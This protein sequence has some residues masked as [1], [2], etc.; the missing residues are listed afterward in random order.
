MKIKLLKHIVFIAFIFAAISLN[1]QPQDFFLK[2][3]N[4]LHIFNNNDVSILNSSF[5]AKSTNNNKWIKYQKFTNDANNFKNLASR[6]ASNPRRKARFEKK[7]QKYLRKAAKYQ[8][9]ALDSYIDANNIIKSKY[10]AKISSLSSPETELLDTLNDIRMFY[11]DSIRMNKLDNSSDMIIR[12]NKRQ[13]QYNYENKVILYMEYQLAILAG[14]SSIITP[15]KEKYFPQTQTVVTN[16]VV[17]DTVPRWDY[18]NDEFFFYPI[19]EEMD[20]KILYSS[21]NFTNL[22][23]YF[24]LGNTAFLD[25]NS[26]NSVYDSVSVYQTKLSQTSDYRKR[27]AISTKVSEFQQ[28]ALALEIEALKKYYSSN[29]LFF[30]IRKERIL[31][32]PLPDTAN[33]SYKKM[34]DYINKAEQFYYDADSSKRKSITLAGI[35][36]RNSIDRGNQ[37]MVT[38][39]EYLENAFCLKYNFDTNNVMIRNKLLTNTFVAIV[40]PPDTTS[41]SNNNST[42]NATT[43]NTRTNN[44]SK[45][46]R[47]SGLF[48][49]SYSSR[50]PV[51][52]STPNGTIY[53]VQVGTSIDLL[54]V[55]E[56]REYDKIYYEQFT[57]TSIKKFLVGDY[58]NYDDAQ[59]TLNKL[60]NS[61]YITAVIVKYVEGKRQGATYSSTYGTTNTSTGSF[62][63]VSQLKV[64]TYLIQLGTYS[65]PKTS[66]DLANYQNVYVRR[67]ANGNYEYFQG[68]Y[69]RY[70]NAEVALP[71]VIQKGF[72]DAKIV[73]F[74]TGKQT[75]VETA[76]RIEGITQNNTQTS[77]NQQTT[78]NNDVVFRIQVGAFSDYLSNDKLNQHFSNLNN[79]YAFHTHQ[80]N[81]LIVYSL[82][83]AKTYQEAQT[84]KQDIVSKG[85]ADCYIIAFKGDVLVP[86][87]DV[88]D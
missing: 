84:I 58:T 78:T 17:T 66:A 22:D 16:I 64:L 2:S 5:D 45:P 11:V 59:T 67:L 3:K 41:N 19:N 27:A 1:A 6:Y 28:Q 25:L 13:A 52:S 49:Y 37:Q 87:S 65:T 43:N 9:K 14:D 79:A 60:K 44:T 74:N 88:T 50:T 18:R 56:L 10:Q 61:G 7:Q 15:L 55:N 33:T 63:N 20:F 24:N 70:N 4:Y 68:P 80:K 32:N 26:T 57:N 35:D 46:Q 40:N 85:F 69:F 75:T 36:K 38:A 12:A 76:L 77:N 71:N 47:I 73:A 81:G 39:L 82:G 72:S 8:I 29:E 23:R 21:D 62:K 53:R 54:P 83:N 31:D 34:I 48:E 86:L 30:Q 42:T 51:L